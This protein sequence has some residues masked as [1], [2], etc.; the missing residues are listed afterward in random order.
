MG[1]SDTKTSPLYERGCNKKSSCC[2]V[3]EA[4]GMPEKELPTKLL[5]LRFLAKSRCC[6]LLSR[7]R[8]LVLADPSRDQPRRPYMWAWQ[9][10]IWWWTAWT[11][12]LMTLTLKEKRHNLVLSI[13]QDRFGLKEQ[14]PECV[15]CW[16]KVRNLRVTCLASQTAM[17]TRTKP[18]LSHLCG[19]PAAFGL[20][21]VSPLVYLRVN[22]FCHQKKN[23]CGTLDAGPQK[24]KTWWRY[25]LS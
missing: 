16:T 13:E 7:N 10:P 17:G 18:L 15:V 22:V 20:I 23:K 8:S 12:S 1:W 4:P 5:T 25:C 14:F 3:S 19:G 21:L 11:T 9:T 24:T 6:S 2:H